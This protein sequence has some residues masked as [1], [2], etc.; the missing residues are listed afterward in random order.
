MAE[1]GDV[2]AN[3][4][5]KDVVTRSSWEAFDVV[6]LAALV[7]LD[8]GAKVAILAA[9]AKRLTSGT[10][11]VARS[12]QGLRAVLYPVSS[13]ACPFLLLF[14]LFLLSFC[15]V[16]CLVDVSLLRRVRDIRFWTSRSIWPTWGS[17]CWSRCTRGPRSSTRS[18]S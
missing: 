3:G 5:G 14:L 17:R 4:V 9:L 10:L 6:F 16:F 18:W 13:I 12:A 1:D 8:A 11:I 7:G 2:D 15:S